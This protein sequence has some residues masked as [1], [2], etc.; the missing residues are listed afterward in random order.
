MSLFVKNWNIMF[1]FINHIIEK[2]IIRMKL[3]KN[4]FIFFILYLFFN[5]D[6]LELIDKSKI[7]T[8]TINFV[9]N[10]NLLIYKKFTKKNYAI[11][12][13]IHFICVWW[14]KRH[15]MIF[16]FKKYELIH[17][18]HKTRRFNMRATMK[19]GDVVVEFKTNIK[20]LKLQIDIKLKWHFHMK[21]IQIK[22]IIQC[23]MLFKIST[24]TWK[25]FFIKMKQIYLMMIWSIMI[26]MSTIWHKFINKLNENPNDKFLITQNKWL[27]MITNVFKTILIWILKIKIIDL[28]F[29]FH[30]NKLQTE[31]KMWLKN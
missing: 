6:L 29:N 3:S 27:R 30:L 22:M 23:I 10:I 14:T 28:L 25:I 13:H 20:L 9:N 21:T 26:Y 11:L 7:K 1:I 16:I 24:F 31:I 19:I 5:A 2:Q 4:L 15:D 18:S 17:L 8:T 12:K